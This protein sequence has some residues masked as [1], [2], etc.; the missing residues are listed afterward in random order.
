MYVILIISK[1]KI[2]IYK[3]LEMEAEIY[4]TQVSQYSTWQT[5]QE[6]IPNVQNA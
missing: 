2:Y 3:F 5:S 4:T 1:K 6:I